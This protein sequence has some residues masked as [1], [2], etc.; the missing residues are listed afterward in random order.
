[1]ILSVAPH[2]HLALAPFVTRFPAPFAELSVPSWL[3]EQLQIEAST[4]VRRD[5]ATRAAVRNLL[6]HGGYKPTGRGKPAAE[7]LVRAAAAGL[8][9]SINVAV[10]A[11]NAV[12]LHSGLPISVK[13]LGSLSATCC[14]GVCLPAASASAP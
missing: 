8:L 10:D 12:S 9:K 13:F 2:P 7:Y 6:R 14:G 5:E 11:C 1:M 4:P 3:V